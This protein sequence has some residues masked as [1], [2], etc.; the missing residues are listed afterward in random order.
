[1]P[2][3]FLFLFQKKFSK[4]LRLQMLTMSIGHDEVL[5]QRPYKEICFEFWITLSESV[6]KH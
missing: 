4:N 2:N 5:L 3:I 6:Y 1:M